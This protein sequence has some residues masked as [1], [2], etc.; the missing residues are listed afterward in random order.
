MTHGIARFWYCALVVLAIGA[1]QVR[2]S[3]TGYGA[4]GDS[5]ADEYQF[6]PPDRSTALNF[7]ELMA[8]DDGVNFGAFSSISRGSPRYQGYANDWALSGAESGDLP[9]NGQRAG[10]DRV[11]VRRWE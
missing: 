1:G 9:A 6:Y 8:Q 2:A 11:H 5:Y 4:L 10:E 3:S 7:V